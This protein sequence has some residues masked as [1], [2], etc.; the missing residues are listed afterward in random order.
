MGGLQRHNDDI[1]NL[2]RAGYLL[3]NVTHR[4]PEEGQVV[5]TPWLG[6]RV[7]FVPHFIRRLTF[8]PHPFIRGLMFFCGLDFHDLTLN[9]ILHISAFT[10]IC[11]AFLRV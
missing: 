8:P 7:L 6:E 3:A 4:A 10:V 9:S 1:E 2:K 11:E 5:P